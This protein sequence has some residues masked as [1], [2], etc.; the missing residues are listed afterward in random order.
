MLRLIDIRR[1]MATVEEM[2][3]S[4]PPGAVATLRTLDNMRAAVARGTKDAGAEVDA[5]L[6][7]A[8]SWD[9]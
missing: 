9:T 5:A 6:K 7:R 8:W 1:L 2:G 3:G 4:T